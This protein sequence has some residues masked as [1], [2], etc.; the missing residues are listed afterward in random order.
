MFD[1]EPRLDAS[2]SLINT[3]SSLNPS[4]SVA[5]AHVYTRRGPFDLP[6]AGAAAECVIKTNDSSSRF[7][8]IC[9]ITGKTLGEHNKILSIN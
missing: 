6:T 7:D 2:G 8:S 5:G 3:E 9:V 4:D 1:A